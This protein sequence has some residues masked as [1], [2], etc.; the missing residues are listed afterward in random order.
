MTPPSEKLA[1][2]LDALR[3]LQERGVVAVRARDLLRSHRER[4]VRHG[5]LLP[6]MKGW[7]VAGAPDRRAG[8]STAWCASFWSFC[9]GYLRARFGAA[10]CLSP[11]QSLLLHAGN[12]TVPAQLLVRAPRGRNRVTALLHDTSLL[13]VRAAMPAAGDAVA[14]DGMR[15][16][17]PAA[18][19]IACPARFFQRH[20]VDARAALALVG[21]ASDLLPGLL[22]GGHGTV[23]GRLAAAFRDVG[24]DAI[25]NEIVETMRAADFGVRESNPF[26]TAPPAR[27][28]RRDAAPVVR[29]L[30][31][32]RDAMRDRVLDRFPRPPGRPADVEVVLARIEDVYVTDAYHSLSI[33]GYHVSPTLIARVRSGGWNPERHAADRAHRDALAARGYWQAYRAVRDS[34]RRAV[35]GESPGAVAEADHRT[36]Y[37]ELFAPSVAAGLVRPADLAGYRDAPVFIQR[38]MHV[39]PSA[40]AVRDAM[41]AL[42]ELL[43]EEPDPAVRAVLGHFLFVHVHPYPDGN[44][45]IGRFLMNLLLTAAGYPWTVIPVERRDAYMA[46][47]EAASVRQ[48]IGPFA[49]FL[50]ALVE[51]QGRPAPTPSLSGGRSGS[52]TAA[53]AESAVSRPTRCRGGRGRAGPPPSRTR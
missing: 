40:P 19:L 22:D 16:F 27:P 6:V 25:A 44:G 11:E 13:E 45:R 26:A 15:A 4:L 24:R 2:S 9:A 32:I 42:F 47:L 29:R 1:G 46:A 34:V 39:P 14:V 17:S 33:E 18:G 30:H 31:L 23:A 20:P 36:W 35:A 28:I 41:P 43:R 12:R 7:Y 52:D 21:D 38:S 49:D 3:S 48:D 53:R 10:W 51:G 50:A 37:R 5:F 8:D